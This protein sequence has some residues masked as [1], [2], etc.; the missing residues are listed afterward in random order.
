MKYLK[1]FEE[2]KVDNFTKQDIIDTIKHD[3]K[4]K[5]FTISDFPEHNPDNYIR[6]VDIAG[7]SIIVDV[8][9]QQYRT[10]L[11]YV[12]KM[13]Y[14]NLN[15]SI[16]FS[17]DGVILKNGKPVVFYHGGSYTGGEFKG[18]AWFTTSKADAKYYAE[19]NG[20]HVTK[21][22]LIVKNPFYSGDI[23]HLNIKLT[24]DI[25]NSAKNRNILNAIKFNEDK[26]LEFIET[27][28][29]TLIASDIGKD[30]VID[31]YKGEIVDVVVF[32]NE[33]ILEI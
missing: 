22:N 7:D 8:D 29:A 15:E 11:E 4:I 10:R 6:P 3:G 13:E 12:T 32:S 16:D 24:D 14:S 25:L 9:G 31:L 19:Q 5:V 23:K 27:N 33:Q 17:N 1:L 30:G 21:A 26:T 28:G 20:G 18:M 2:Y